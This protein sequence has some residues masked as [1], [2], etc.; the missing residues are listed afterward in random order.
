MTT[1]LWLLIASLG[2]YSLYLGAQSLILRWRY[3]VWYAASARDDAPKPEGD[4][5]GR[6]ER[7]LRNFNETYVPLVILLIVAHLADRN[8]PLV[9]WGAGLWFAAR[10]VYL[11]LY[12][13]GVFMVRSLV[14]LVSALGL[15]LM[16]AGIVF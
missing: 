14:W 6:A 16:F 7:A 8:D 2:V 4:L 12:L 10:I 11:P 9:L 3:G 1:E 15:L 5:L 13:F